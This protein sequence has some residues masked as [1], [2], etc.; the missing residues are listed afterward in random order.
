MTAD[1]LV[2]NPELERATARPPATV[3]GLDDAPL[4][5]CS[6]DWPP[7]FPLHDPSAPRVATLADPDGAALLTVPSA[8]TVTG[9]AHLLAAWLS[10]R[11]DLPSLE[12][13][14]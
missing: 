8:P 10:G 1:P 14:K 11:G 13:W 4:A 2:L 3:R 12:A 7:A 6:A 9:P 5:R